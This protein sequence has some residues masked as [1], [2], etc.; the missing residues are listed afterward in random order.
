MHDL[1]H[2]EEECVFAVS[3][4]LDHKF[5]GNFFNFSCLL[6]SQGLGKIQCCQS[7]LLFEM[8]VVHLLLDNLRDPGSAVKLSLSKVS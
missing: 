6:G 7:P 1:S 2:V 5:W 4:F 3:H 8:N